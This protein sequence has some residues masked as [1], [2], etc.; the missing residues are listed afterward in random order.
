M[1]LLENILTHRDSALTCIDIF[2]THYEAVFDANI[3]ASG[4]AGKVRKYKGRSADI[5]PRFPDA[6]FALI[7]IDGGHRADEVRADA[8]E[9]WRLAEP[10]GIIIFDDYLW[11][12][13]L[14][15]D[16]RPKQAIDRFLREFGASLEVLHKGYQV[17]VRKS[18]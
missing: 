13:Q 7:Y 16:E 11:A 5:L 3:A 4:V 1:W 14:P 12:L 2:W 10:G 18:G 8:Q 15:P 6:A 17:I 9:A